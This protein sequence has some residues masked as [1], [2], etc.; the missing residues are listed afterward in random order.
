M[1]IYVGNLNFKTTELKL[2]R[3]FEALGD[4]KNVRIVE[5]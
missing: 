3:H 4:I 1:S 2:G 5:D